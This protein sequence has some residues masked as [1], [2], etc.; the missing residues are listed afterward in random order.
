MKEMGVIQIRKTPQPSRDQLCTNYLRSL[1][2]PA[3]NHSGS[4]PMALAPR[5][6]GLRW[7][8]Q[9]R[10]PSA[11]QEAD[12]NKVWKGRQQR[13]FQFLSAV[14]FLSLRFWKLIQAGKSPTWAETGAHREAEGHPRRTWVWG[15]PSHLFS[16]ESISKRRHFYKEV[17][18]FWDC[19]LV[20][21]S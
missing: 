9:G 4:L 10:C 21:F 13:P 11:H 3:H 1:Q 8:D 19:T 7:Q 6:A 2:S 12:K 18:L 14:S 17:L 5:R 20:V 16:R 15:E